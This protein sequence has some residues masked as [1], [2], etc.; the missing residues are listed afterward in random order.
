MSNDLIKHV[1]DASFDADVLKA[2]GPVLVDYWA[3]WCG[4]CKM[5]APVL[6][7][8]AGTYEGKLTIAKLNID[9]NQET[10][11]KHGVRGIPTLMLFKNGE[12]AATK[13][14]ALSKS[15]LQAFLDANI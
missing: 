2:A 8:I 14:G 6:D 7:D 1:S 13:V 3:E 11:A 12:V 15:Q 5:I 4:P 9:D 10:P